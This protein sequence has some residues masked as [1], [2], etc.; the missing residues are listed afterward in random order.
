[1]GGARECRGASR[2]SRSAW[3]ALLALGLMVGSLAGLARANGEPIEIELR[4]LSGVSNFGPRDASGRAR[5]VLVEGD[6]RLSVSKLP[7]EKDARYEGWIVNTKT[8]E[9]IS[10]GK[11]DPAPDGAVD[12]STVV[13]NL[14]EREFDLF[15]VT[16]EP[17]PDPSPAPDARVVLAGRRVVLG[18]PIVVTAVPREGGAPV[19]VVGLPRTG[20]P[21]LG[22]ALVE[23]WGPV[24]AV[25]GGLGA[26]ALAAW[27]RRR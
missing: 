22:P 9:M 15:M 7:P 26:L 11:F 24:L 27:R 2:L 12:Y 18:P 21:A 14:G 25:A 20:A 3:A 6:V 5:I 17:E 1:M 4:Y 16:V 8:K 13:N 19:P 23:T 10:V